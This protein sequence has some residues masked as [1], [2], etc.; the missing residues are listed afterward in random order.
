MLFNETGIIG[1]AIIGLTN[2]ITG[3][4]YLTLFSLFFV[5]MMFFLALNLPIELSTI[6]ILPLMILFMAESSVDWKP[7][8]GILVLYLSLVFGRYWLR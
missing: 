1:T 6:L 4:I 8:A 5:I 7:V 2:S 3:D